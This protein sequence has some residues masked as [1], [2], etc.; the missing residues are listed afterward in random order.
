M[1]AVIDYGMGN[2]RSVVNALGV[3]GVPASI[4]RHPEDLSRAEKIILPGVGAFG[5][6]MKNLRA[7]GWI[8]AMEE[9]VRD[10]GKP[11]LGICLGLQLLATRGTEHGIHEG[12]NWMPGTVERL[13]ANGPALRVP[14]IGWN[15]V[16]FLKKDG[17]YAGLDASQAFY[18]V[19]SYVFRP[20]DPD[21]V[22]GVCSYGVEFA[23][24]VEKDNIHATQFHPEKSHKAGLT[25]LRN[26]VEARRAIHA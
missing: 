25:V 8:E 6:G 17:L 14:H 11:F 22:S 23:A 20:V 12:L 2:L 19:H 24:S 21:V 18:F 15:D 1:L 5:D 26:F 13:P 3:L 4:A 9:E 10:K 7:I 16:N